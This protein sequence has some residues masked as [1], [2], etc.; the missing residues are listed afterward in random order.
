MVLRGEREDEL[1]LVMNSEELG[2]CGGDS[3]MFLSRL[4]EKGV[5]GEKGES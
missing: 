1:K 4:R 3:K 5:V 2:A